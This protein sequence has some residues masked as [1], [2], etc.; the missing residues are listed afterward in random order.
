MDWIA[1]IKKIDLFLALLSNLKNVSVGRFQ[2][3]VT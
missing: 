1:K 2:I 3:T